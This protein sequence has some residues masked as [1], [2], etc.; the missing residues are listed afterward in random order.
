MAPGGATPESFVARLYDHSGKR[1]RLPYK[2][3]GCGCVTIADALHFLYENKL[4]ES[5]SDTIREEVR[6]RY[7]ATARGESFCDEDAAF[8]PAAITRRALQS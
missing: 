5:S 7:G 3:R 8:P 1:E 2:K 4:A 6:Q